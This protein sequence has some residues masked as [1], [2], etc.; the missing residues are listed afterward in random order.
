MSNCTGS[1]FVNCATHQWWVGQ[2]HFM[3]PEELG[4]HAMTAKLGPNVLDLTLDQFQELL[5]GQPCPTCGTTVEKIKTGSTSG[6]ICTQCQ[7]LP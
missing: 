7:A 5:K 4:A 1:S 6:F 3:S 2:A